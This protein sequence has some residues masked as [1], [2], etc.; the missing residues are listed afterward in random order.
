LEKLKQEGLAIL[1]SAGCNPGLLV[2]NDETLDALVAEGLKSKAL[3][4]PKE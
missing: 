1:R 3:R 4:I 2:A